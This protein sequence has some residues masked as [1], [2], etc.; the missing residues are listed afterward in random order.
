MAALSSCC[1]KQR[2]EQAAGSLG[3][4][5]FFKPAKA[6]K[7]AIGQSFPPVPSGQID[8][9]AGNSAGNNEKPRGGAS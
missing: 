8:Q 9:S 7:W 4:K 6:G 5:S 2:R 1:N 3:D